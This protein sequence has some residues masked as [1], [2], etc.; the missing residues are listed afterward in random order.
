MLRRRRDAKAEAAREAEGREETTQAGRQRR[1][2]AGGLHGRIEPGLMERIHSLYLHIPFCTWVCKYCDF[3]TYAVLEGLVPAYVDA[4]IAEIRAAAG[5]HSV[6]RLDTI[7]FGGG[8]PS[9]LSGEQ[10]GRV[11]AAVR[12]EM[13]IARGAEV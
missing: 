4:L 3:N 13:G 2:S 11:L 6:G 7:F 9:L 8:T 1:N 5:R 12:S 10:V